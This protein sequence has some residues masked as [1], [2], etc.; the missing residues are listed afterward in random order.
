MHAGYLYGH[1]YESGAEEESDAG[2]LPFLDI[3]RVASTPNQSGFRFFRPT[4]R[5]F[6]AVVAV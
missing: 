5:S 2:G 6:C 4:T 1:R 3:A